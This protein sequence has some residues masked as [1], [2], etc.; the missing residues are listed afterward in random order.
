M[1]RFGIRLG[2]NTLINCDPREP[3]LI[4]GDRL[5][6]T[7]CEFRN[8]NCNAAASHIRIPVRRTRWITTRKNIEKGLLEEGSQRLARGGTLS[9]SLFARFIAPHK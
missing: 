1:V 4:L 8:V 3:Q 7:E 6:Q 9:S 5:H 2:M